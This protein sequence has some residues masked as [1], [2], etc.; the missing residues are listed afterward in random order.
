M[1]NF[2]KNIP[3]TILI[4]FHFVGLIGFLYFPEVFKKLSPVNLLLSTALILFTSKQTHIKFYGSMVAIAFLGFF[5]EVIGVKT[6]FIFGSYHYGTAM[7]I[8][9]LAVPLLIGLNWSISLYITSQ[10]C[11]FKNEI[12]NAIFGA[13][14][15]TFLDFFIEQSASKLDFWYWENNNIPIQNYIAWFLISFILNLIFQKEINQTGNKT[16]K[17]YYLIEIT[18]FSILFLL[19]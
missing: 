2:K 18:F 4:I 3:I 12:L 8:K 19:F 5:I 9:I 17:A 6:G 16:A 15:M 1:N 10:F 13:F 7:G 11:K 14:L